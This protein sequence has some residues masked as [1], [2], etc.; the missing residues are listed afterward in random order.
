V[1]AAWEETFCLTAAEAL[2]CGTPVVAAGA[3]GLAEVVD[4][5]RTGLL[6]APGRGAE[7]AAAL[8]WLLDD[9]EARDR[10]GAA[11]TAA[12]RVRFDER[13][14]VEELHAFCAHAA[15]TG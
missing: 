2:A 13:R 11:A 4:H 9:G 1:H 14:M 5:E 6:V 12:A 7:L 10:M 3:G 8:A 15:E